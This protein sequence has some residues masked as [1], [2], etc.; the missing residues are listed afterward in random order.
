MAKFGKEKDEL[1]IES[2]KMYK[3]LY[4]AK[5]TAK[6]FKNNIAKHKC[7]EEISAVIGFP[8]AE[9]KKRWKS[10]RDQYTK[11]RKGESTSTE[12]TNSNWEYMSLM[13]FLSNAIK[14]HEAN[15]N[16]PLQ[17]IGIEFVK[18][19]NSDEEEQLDQQ[20][21]NEDASVNIKEIAQNIQHATKRNSLQ[22][23]TRVMARR[24]AQRS[25]FYEKRINKVPKIKTPMQ[26]F[27]E[28][29]ADIVDKLPPQ[30]Q[31]EVRLKVCQIVTE[32]ELKHHAHHDPNL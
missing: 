2:V 24:H 5:N 25:T 4:D 18:E 19:E 30:L 20:S 21:V 26:K 31:A 1:L 7:W 3:S 32:T 9:C 13:S 12:R 16:E 8:V 17:Y 10:L 22:P 14:I 29:M 6:N 27:F 15:D 11:K 23:I 28:S